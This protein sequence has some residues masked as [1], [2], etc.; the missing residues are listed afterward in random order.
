MW[1][2]YRKTATT[3][4]A[5]CE[6]HADVE[7]ALRQA[8]LDAGLFQAQNT[9]VPYPRIKTREG[10]YASNYPV[11]LAM[12]SN[13]DVYPVAADVFDQMYDHIPVAPWE[14]PQTVVD[15]AVPNAA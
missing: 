1:A 11:W 12:D 10:W 7:A 8:S 2:R 5:W 4:M 6:G 13:G 9:P 3:P 15:K 14:R